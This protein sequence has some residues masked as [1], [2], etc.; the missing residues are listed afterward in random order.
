METQCPYCG[1][2]Y[3]VFD[4]FRGV[5]A[6]CVECGTVFTVEPMPELPTENGKDKEV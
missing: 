6:P 2:V 5:S 4:L 3:K 1:R